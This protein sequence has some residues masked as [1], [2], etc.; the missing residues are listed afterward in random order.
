MCIRL[1]STLSVLVFPLPQPGV[2]KLQPDD[3]RLT[4][5]A[6][7]DAL[8]EHA[9]MGV[10]LF[11]ELEDVTEVACRE[12]RGRA[13]YAFA[14]VV[15]LALVGVMHERNGYSELLGHHARED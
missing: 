5:R 2:R 1:L 9:L 10:R 6:H 14:G 7:L 12:E 15:S 11:C 3:R 8:H 4:S 13:S